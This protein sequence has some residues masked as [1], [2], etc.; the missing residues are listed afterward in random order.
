LDALGVRYAAATAA[1]DFSG[2]DTLIVGKAAL[3]PEGAG[4]DI[5]R[6]RDGLK[7]IVFEQTGDVLEKRFGFRVAEYGMRWVFRRVPDHPLLAG[8]GDEH[9]RDWRG[10]ATL[11]PPRL[12]YERGRL[13]NGSPTVN[14]CGI[15]VTRL[16]RCGN[17]GNVAS[18]LIEKPACGDFLAVLDCG[19]SLQYSPLLQFREGKGM[20]LFCQMDVNGRTE[21]DPA[22]DA[23]LRN[24][25]GY[26][27]AWKA[28]PQR[29]PVYVGDPAGRRYLESA[30]VAA[31]AYAGGFSEG[32]MLIAGP[33]ARRELRAVHD[34]PTLAIGIGQEDADALLPHQ[35]SMIQKEH[36][37][38]YFEPFGMESPF[39]GISPAEVHN[40][41]PRVMP[42]VGGGGTLV[43][44]GVLAAAD[45]GVVFSQL[46][47]WQFDYSGGKMNVKRTFR[48]VACLTARLLANLGA[49]GETPLLARFGNPAGA[50]EQR[51]LEGL[52]LDVPEEWDDPY[53]HFR[54]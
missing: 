13:F 22:A 24:I 26:A 48:R 46:A 17:R 3:A 25:L 50:D 53:R 42:L 30:G 12:N 39:A 38:A 54:W 20:V 7:V 33:G 19:Y 37:A 4:P 43:G 32:Q 27:A 47:P 35:V 49:A 31:A 18:A 41:D 45:G 21:Q 51:W 9:L 28:R 44:D 11:L 34:V 5:T 6:V 8:L 2:Y 10:S 52:Y 23:L 14:W 15:P 36:I 29:R 40:R 16:W 1:S